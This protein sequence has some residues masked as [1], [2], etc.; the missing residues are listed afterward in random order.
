M[1]SCRDVA[2]MI[3]AEQMLRVGRLTRLRVQVH[4]LLCRHCRRYARELRAI[5]RGARDAASAA[6]PSAAQLDRLARSVL[7]RG[8]A[9]G[10]S[11]QP[12]L[13]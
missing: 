3:A 10:R 8:G 1:L 9:V 6:M 12:P 5:G 13:T 4:L 2:A 7:D 11:P